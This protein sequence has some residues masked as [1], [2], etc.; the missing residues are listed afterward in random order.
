MTS[1]TLDMS[2]DATATRAR[3]SGWRP[4]ALVL[5]PAGLLIAGSLVGLL[6]T[7]DTR[8]AHERLIGLVLATV[9]VTLAVAALPR[10]AANSWTLPAAAL[11]ALL[12]GVWV[13]A[14]TGADV[15]RGPL[16]VAL[17][18]LFRPLF[19]LARVTDSVDIANTRFIVGYNGLADLCLVATFTAAA[20]LTRR[21]SRGLTWLLATIGLAALVLLLGTGSRGGL[22]GLAAGIGLIGLFAWPRRYALLV[23]A[24]A[25]LAAAL[26]MVGALDKGLEFSSTSGRVAYWADLARLLVEYPLTGVGL[27]VSTANRVA[28]AYEINPDPE[29]IFYAHNTFVQAYLEQGPLGAV[30][31]LLAPLLAILAVGYG[32]KL[33]VTDG[34][35]PLL[36]AG[37]GSMGALQAHGLTDQVVTTNVGTGLVLLAL[38]AIVVSLTPAGQAA[39]YNALARGLL[40]LLAAATVLG[41]LLL[42]LPAGRGQV[43]LDLGGLQLNR[44]LSMDPQGPGRAMALAE[45]EATLSLALAQAPEHA[46]VLRNL[47]RVRSARFD[48]VGALEA[49]RRA[50]ESPRLDAFDM[51]QIA[52]VYRDA[53]FAAEAYAWASRAY[54]ARGRPPE[55]SVM[56]VYAENTLTSDEG[57]HRARTLA[58]Q[59]EAAM[60]AR[61]FGEAAELFRQALAFKPESVYLQD[62]LGAAERAVARYGP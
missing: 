18:A 32:R 44:A 62:R 10:A 22:N 16:G 35:R 49:L 17:A 40:A 57:G 13:I 29:R 25:P 28:L 53:G 19:G 31:M 1:A 3:T 41:A 42:V 39:L 43:L 11:V 21:P 45:A 8:V 12:G 61:S 50:A 59:A 9:L 60:R 36:L 6:G 52:H 4:V 7:L 23:L 48:D 58:E 37:L 14:A 27:G 2:T 54:S 30:G 5:A 33:G 55:D 24:A 47:A 51:L 34:R 56:R 26:V 15:F 38:A 46:G 20:G